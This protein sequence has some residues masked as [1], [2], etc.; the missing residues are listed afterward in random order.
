VEYGQ[1]SRN[2]S[3]PIPSILERL[4]GAFGRGQVRFH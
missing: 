3:S 4:V 2:F 1:G